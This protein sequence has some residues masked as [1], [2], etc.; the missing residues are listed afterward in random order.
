[1]LLAAAIVI[2]ITV[3]VGQSPGEKALRCIRDFACVLVALP[4]FCLNHG[5]IMLACIILRT[6]PSSLKLSL[7][8]A[9]FSRY[10]TTTH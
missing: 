9:I 2:M 10:Y 8:R 3:I 4:K 1:M 7:H 6:N 5:I